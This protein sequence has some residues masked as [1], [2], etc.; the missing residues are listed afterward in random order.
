[1]YISA[2][3]STVPY[4]HSWWSRDHGNGREF[5]LFSDNGDCY[6]SPTDDGC[7]YVSPTIDGYCCLL[8]TDAYDCYILPTDN[9]DYNI[10][11]DDGELL[12][13]SSYDDYWEE[14]QELLFLYINIDL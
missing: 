10:S 3:Q 11:A 8:P 13:L 7:C 14:E 2:F 9:G 5:W 1:M 12:T 6:I 4:H